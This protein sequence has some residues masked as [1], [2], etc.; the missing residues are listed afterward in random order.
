MNMLLAQ[1]R[2]GITLSICICMSYRYNMLQSLLKEIDAFAC[3]PFMGDEE[4]TNLHMM[5]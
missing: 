3:T 2:E 4:A 1:L 5:R